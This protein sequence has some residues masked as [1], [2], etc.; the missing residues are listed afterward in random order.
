MIRTNRWLAAVLATACTLWPVQGWPC[1]LARMWEDHAPF[2][3][4]TEDALI[5]W[6]RQRHIEHFVRNATF[7]TK[8]RSFGFLV[9]VPGRPTLAE[10]S[11]RVFKVIDDAIPVRMEDRTVWHHEW[12]GCGMLDMLHLDYDGVGAAAPDD[13]RGV[14]V[15]EQTRVAGLDA[16]VLAASETAALSHWLGAHGFESREALTRWL[17]V[18]VAKKWNVVAFRYER[19]AAPSNAPDDDDSLAS[20]AVR[21]SFST[22]EPVYPYFEP[23]DTP[24]TKDRR[25]HLYVVADAPMDAVL[26]D[27]QASPWTAKRV[28]ASQADMHEVASAVPGLELAPP[29]RW[30][31]EFMDKTTKRPPS[32]LVFRPSRSLAPV[33]RVALHL[34]YRRGVPRVP[35]EALFALIALAVWRWRRRANANA[36]KKTA[37]GAHDMP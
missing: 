11:D 16:T 13:P 32:D 19:P 27:A 3:A 26:V 6:D 14:T 24:E 1:G 33:E 12:F 4:T 25:L 36:N 34:T 37:A 9:P 10:A 20:Q 15:L 5:V 17:A 29:L 35:V 28:S 18:Y 21:I 8:A 23:S 2:G 22:D 30:V 7:G 31:T